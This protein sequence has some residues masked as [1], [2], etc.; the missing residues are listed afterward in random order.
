MEAPSFLLS[1][2]SMTIVKIQGTTMGTIF[3][4]TY[5]ALS[6]GYDEKEIYAVIRKNFTLPVSNYFQ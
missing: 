1:K 5:T 3:A 2:N 6:M 4:P